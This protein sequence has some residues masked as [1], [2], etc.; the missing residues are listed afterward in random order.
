MST[1]YSILDDLER[2]KKQ[3]DKYYVDEVTWLQEM[4]PTVDVEPG[5]Q[6]IK[7]KSF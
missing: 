5:S 3:K 2:G 1:R 6:T 7:V 4:L